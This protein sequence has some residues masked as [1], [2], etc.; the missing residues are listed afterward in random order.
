MSFLRR[1][2]SRFKRLDA[3][4]RWHDI[5]IFLRLENPQNSNAIGIEVVYYKLD[6][7]NELKWE[8]DPDD[9]EEILAVQ[10]ETDAQGEPIQFSI[11][12][13]IK[14]AK[15]AHAGKSLLEQ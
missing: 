13:M 3:S 5:D 4:L 8:I 2:E 7:P 11:E 12:E 14:R 15:A 1:Q 9:G 10:Y 6:V